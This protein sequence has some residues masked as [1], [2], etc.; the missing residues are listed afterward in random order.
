MTINKCGQKYSHYKVFDKHLKCLDFQFEVG[1][2]YKHPGELILGENGFH[3][4]EKLIDCFNYKK[5]HL[6]IRVCEVLLGGEQITNHD[7]TAALEIMVV[8]ELAFWEIDELVNEGE[9]NLGYGNKGKYNKGNN[10][11]GHY[12]KGDNNTGNGNTGDYNKGD[13]NTGYFNKGDFNNGNYNNGDFNKGGGNT[14]NDNTGELKCLLIKMVK[15]LAIIKY[16]TK[17]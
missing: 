11:K 9:G 8:R 10:N 2:T 1:K 13:G 16:L 12:N 7:K 14:Y 3:A 4:C 5:F 6:S 15:N 17:I